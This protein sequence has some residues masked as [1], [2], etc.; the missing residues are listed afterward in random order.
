MT[1]SKSSLY[2]PVI[3]TA[4]SL[5][6]ISLAAC[7]MLQYTSQEPEIGA[8]AYTIKG[9]TVEITLTKVP[10]LS[11]VGG[12]ATIVDEK[13]PNYLIIVQPEAGE[14]VAASSRCTHRG[15]A[16]SYKHET[17][18]FQCSS[19]GGSKYKLDGSV[20]KGP[21]EEPLI[22]CPVSLEGGILIIDISN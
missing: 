3:L 16:L 7:S 4:L 15:M 13:L 9:E 5:L 8:D 2:K 12:T 20:T 19:G 22:I 1:R 18:E 11:Q 17:K 6:L 10:S 14:Y 21:A